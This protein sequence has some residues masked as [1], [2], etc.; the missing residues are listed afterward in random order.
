[1][2]F[3]LFILLSISG[4]AS[5]RNHPYL[6]GVPWFPDL[7]V[8]HLSEIE[9]S[10]ATA[11]TTTNANSTEAPPPTKASAVS[12]KA[13]LAEP[14]AI[15]SSALAALPSTARRVVPAELGVQ[16]LQ[17]VPLDKEGNLLLIEELKLYLQWQSN[18]AYIKN[19][20]I[21]YSEEPVDI[22]GELD[23]MAVG[24]NSGKFD[25]EYQF[26]L[27]LMDLFN[28]G[29]DNHLAWQPDILAGLMQFQRTPGT[30]L[31]SISA[32][33]IQLPEIFAY[34]DIE[35]S[36]NDSSFKPSAVRM[37][38]GL[39]AEQYLQTIAPQADFHDPDTRWNALFPSQPML[40]TG[41]NF[42]GSFRT[43]KYAGPSTTLTFANG[44]SRT[45]Q[46]LAVVFGNFS[47]VDSGKKF[48]DTFCTG[49]P[50]APVKTTSTTAPSSTVVPA[51][52][53][54]GYPKAVI[55][56]PQ[57]AIA[58]YHL[59][60]E[61]YEVC[62]HPTQKSTSAFIPIL[63]FFFLNLGHRYPQYPFLP[64]PRRKPLPI[65]LPPV[66]QHVRRNWENETDIRFPR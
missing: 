50:P 10:D 61:G 19:P 4:L 17:S 39:P 37:I 21:D 40:A 11:N 27:D 54:T 42:L 51:P 38:N 7:E 65:H 24:L 13:G 25:N 62:F 28:R 8:Q 53:Q 56:H 64:L 6:Y 32:D 43:G 60:E 41:I 26:H 2:F 47:G 36:N 35:I 55:M 1:M 22:L 33:G 48:F 58:G 49:A 29:Y 16:C 63:S 44:T 46:N 3:R 34:R 20:P 45:D 57:G 30:E 5:A 15:V 14:C 18:L 12:L 52:T 31:V 9:A 59:E 66:H 23:I